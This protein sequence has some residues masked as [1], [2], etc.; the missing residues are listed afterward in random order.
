MRYKK[1]IRELLEYR[2]E[3]TPD[4]IFGVYKTWE[5]S[6]GELEILVNRLSNGLSE[7]GITPCH[8]VG[9]MLGNH[10]HHIITFFALAKL[11][12]VWIP[13]DVNLRGPS[14]DFLIEKTRP[15]A[16]II[17]SP[18]WPQL[19]QSV[20]KE[21][22]ERI[23][24]HKM[25]TEIDFKEADVI[26]FRSLLNHA[27]SKP[28]QRKTSLD[29]IRSINFTSG[30]TGPPK[31]VLMSERM[32][33]AC[34]TG[35]AL[36]SNAEKGDVFLLWEPLYHNSGVQMCILAL[37]K[38]AKLAIVERFSA[39][40]FWDQIRSYKV[41]K[42]H[43]L[44]GLLDILLKYPPQAMDKDHSVKIAFGGGC[45]KR[46]WRTFEERFGV[47]I[48]EVY[49]LTEASCF[50]TINT[51]GKVGSIGKPYPYFD[52][53]VIDSDGNPLQSGRI[54]E[55]VIREKQKGLITKGYLKDESGTELACSNGWLHTGDLAYRDAEGDFFFVGRK[56]DS[57]R[58]RGQNISAW[59]VERVLNYHPEI[60][61]SAVIGVEAEVGEQ[62][63]KAFIVCINPGNLEP[64][65]I[66]KW[67]EQ[68]MPYYQ[69]PRYIT[70][71]DSFDKTSTQR[72]RKET[73]SKNK[74]DCWDLE[75]TGYKLKHL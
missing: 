46:S 66:V 55:I 67:C 58:R 18:F 41:T 48:Q 8:R 54:G 62:D 47:K 59:E 26:E 7:I 63:L 73:L 36:A 5:I 1:T 13:F 51:S 52:I 15:I 35:A 28:P 25:E 61:E 42:M 14:L 32:L 60:K 57:I 68:C 49:G 4:L 17:D 44:G 31:G 37:E 10:P 56:K 45:S 29:E 70:F 69:I 64:L 65:E 23:I 53:D 74:D 16:M 34:A 2:A 40:K 33:R 30:T 11:G 72:I 9:V 75:K 27:N 21:C 43:Y 38:E 22:I 12:A 39:S 3:S 71:V 20:Q 24:V 50:S 19:Q 6:F